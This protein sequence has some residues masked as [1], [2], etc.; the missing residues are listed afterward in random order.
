MKSKPTPDSDETEETVN[1]VDLVLTTGEL[2][3]V[4]SDVV[5]K[6]HTD[7]NFWIALIG[8]AIY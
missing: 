8:Q 2:L 5:A 6:Q 7:K 1:E 3:E 4:V